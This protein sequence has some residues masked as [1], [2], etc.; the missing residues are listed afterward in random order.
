MPSVQREAATGPDG[1]QVSTSEQL[2]TPG[3][4]FPE[5]TRTRRRAVFHRLRLVRNGMAQKP[6]FGVFLTD[7]EARVGCSFEPCKPSILGAHAKAMLL[8]LL[9][10]LL[11]EV[12]KSRACALKFACAL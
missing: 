3:C 9:Q 1:V 5:Q 6:H 4:F 11:L 2:S 7:N 12:R 8:A 10:V